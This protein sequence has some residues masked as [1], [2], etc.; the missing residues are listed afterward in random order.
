[1]THRISFKHRLNLICSLLFKGYLPLNLEKISFFC[2]RA[3]GGILSHSMTA[4][5]YSYTPFYR[6]NKADAPYHL[7]VLLLFQVYHTTG[8]VSL[9]HVFLGD[10]LHCGPGADD[11]GRV[12]S[13][14]LLGI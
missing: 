9:I 12:H 10:E 13:L 3:G 14:L 11:P 6:K 7:V 1:M 5:V 8:S 2:Q 4:L